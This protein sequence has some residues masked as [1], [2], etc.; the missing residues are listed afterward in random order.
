MAYTFTPSVDT[1]YVNFFDL[2]GVTQLKSLDKNTIDV[3]WEFNG[4]IIPPATSPDR[5]TF[6]IEGKDYNDVQYSQINI[7]GA[8]PTSQ[9]DF[10]AK[11]AAIFPNLGKPTGATGSFTSA[12]SKTITVTNGI[13]TSII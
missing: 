5:V 12:N 6:T 11:M 1:L 13:I 7:N 2:D 10:E 4:E 9:S 8:I 3:T